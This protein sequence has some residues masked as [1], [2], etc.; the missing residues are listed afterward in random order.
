MGLISTVALVSQLIVQ[1]TWD[2]ELATRWRETR[3]SGRSFSGAETRGLIVYAAQPTNTLKLALGLGTY[4][5]SSDNQASMIGLTSSGGNIRLQRALLEWSDAVSPQWSG[6]AHLGRFAPDDFTTALS[7]DP[8]TAVS[9]ARQRISYH[10]DSTTIHVITQQDSLAVSPENQALGQPFEN[11]WRFDMGLKGSLRTQA[12]T[13]STTLVH[14]HF[15]SLSLALRQRSALNGSSFQ[16][17]LAA[18]RLSESFST[19]V[20]QIDAE[21]RPLDIRSV[22]RGAFA[23]NWR[24]H[25]NQHSYF[26]EALIGNEWEAEELALSFSYASL[27]PDVMPAGLL[28]P[29]YGFANR[30]AYR[31]WVAYFPWSLMKISFDFMQSIAQ[32]RSDL[33]KNRF[34][35]MGG[36]EFRWTW[37]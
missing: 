34:N 18:P 1:D 12:A 37:P 13:F 24:T 20:I 22:L 23:Y 29:R 28:D 31:I 7:G 9:G 30:D 3:E 21:S 35:F 19:T 8:S 17:D 33:Q 26:L 11:R 27:E 10:H 6:G 36:L 2:L 4:D 5:E 32:T 14:H 15:S 16:G 25:E